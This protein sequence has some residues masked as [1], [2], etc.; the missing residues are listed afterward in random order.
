MYALSRLVPEVSWG[1][2]RGTTRG[3]TAVIGG[4]LGD[5]VEG[6]RGRPERAGAAAAALRRRSHSAD[7]LPPRRD[8]NALFVE[9]WGDRL[10]GCTRGST[11]H[12]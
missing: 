4:W 1:S 3:G 6:G 7:S 8:R 5:L 10:G 11:M 2:Y 9:P 12:H